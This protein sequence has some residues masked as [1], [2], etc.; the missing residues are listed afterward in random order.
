MRPMGAPA[1]DVGFIQGLLSAS[2]YLSIRPVTA[3]GTARDGR[4][5]CRRRRGRLPGRR[6]KCVVGRRRG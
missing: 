2:R 5:A 4:A 6:P 1:L 3:A